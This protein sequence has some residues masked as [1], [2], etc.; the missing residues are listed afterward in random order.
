MKSPHLWRPVLFL[1]SV[2]LAAPGAT[3]AAPA[4]PTA[5][6]TQFANELLA[7]MTLEEKVG[8]TVI[9]TSHWT[10]TGPAADQGPLEEQIRDGTCGNVFN[11]RTVAYNR[12]LQQIAVEG[13]R[14][15][16]PLLFGYDVI[17][18]YNTIFPIPLGEAASW[19]LPRIE[20]SARIAALKAA[21]SGVNWTFAPMVDIARDPRWGRVA[22]GAG[23]DPFLGGAIARARV[24]GFQGDNFDGA[25]TVLA[26]VKHYAGY[27]AAESGRDYNTVDL[28]ERQLREVY[29]PPYRAAIDAGAWSV[30]TAFNDLDGIP[31]TANGFLLRQVLRDEWGFR[32]FVVTDYNAVH[33]LTNHG[34]AA[35]D[36][37][38]AEAALGAGVD[39]DM[40][41][42][43]YH[44]QLVKLVQAGRVQVAAIEAAARRVLEAKYML[45][46]F[47]DPYRYL[48]APREA[49]LGHAP[50]HLAE[51]TEMARR[52]LVLL[53]NERGVL[54]LHAGMKLA[55]IGPIGDSRDL[56]G[57]W[58]GVGRTD[59]V[60]TVLAA[61]KSANAG[62][63]V[64]FARGCELA[65]D[66]RP[67]LAA[68]IAA[69]QEADVVILAL[70]ESSAMTGEAASRTNIGLP[71]RQAELLAAVQAV[72]KPV[73]TLVFSGR[74]L[75]LENEAALSDA[76]LAAWFPGSSGGRAIADVLFG[77]VNPSG[78]L[79]ITFPR[80]LGQVPIYYAVKNTGR[81]VDPDK[82]REKYKSSYLDSRNDPLFPFGFGLGYTTFTYAAPT[83]SSD[84]L[85]P[86]GKLTATVRVTNTGRR[87]GA[88]VVQ[89]YVRQLVSS[90]TR[91]LLTLKDFQ[92]IEL[93][94]GESRDVTFTIGEEQLAYLRRDLT[95]GTEPGEFRLFL[96][97][98]SR[99][100]QA[101]R[102]RLAA[103]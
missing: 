86:G 95:L 79:P 68:A 63:E 84:V 98:N 59:G 40:Q 50:E 80:S 73:V 91:P 8:Q 39:M 21:A 51:A 58:K 101:V 43:A 36:A 94:A 97:P 47:R 72:G 64:G 20:A 55:V 37:A 46:L 48:D 53:K 42:G 31:A 52:T 30:M 14:L 89:L 6:A 35:D 85:A 87:P 65:T 17:H 75:A 23:E 2:V 71:G 96:G 41:S 28:S 13:S 4:R 16:I 49:A 99:D 11:A 83:L 54:P 24:H 26:C 66:A 32:G 102:F 60:E 76:M 15:H 56:L 9:F 93:A 34:I 61:I 44:D 33:E 90:A 10:S 18:G 3:R 81:P 69:A 78:R 27:G 29:L 38:A 7:R 67:D 100:L 45:G 57:C 5:A 103:P 22:E 25:T 74:P 88:D 1:L 92:R 82:P 70:G 77:V 19:D 12:R 62:G